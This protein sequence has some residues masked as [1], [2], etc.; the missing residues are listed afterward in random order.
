ML[1]KGVKIEYDVQA[2]FVRAESAY[3]E[4]AELAEGARLEIV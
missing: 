3:G 2:D 1:D 4:V